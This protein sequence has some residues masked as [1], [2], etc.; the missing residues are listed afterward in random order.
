MIVNALSGEYW[1]R[2][3]GIVT[4][5]YKSAQCVG[6]FIINV[7]HKG[8]LAITVLVFFDFANYLFFFFRSV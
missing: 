3:K 8:V 1:I 4:D 5:A 6:M 2:T 7:N